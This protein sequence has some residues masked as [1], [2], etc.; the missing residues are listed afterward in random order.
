MMVGRIDQLGPIQPGGK[1]GKSDQVQG[2]DRTDVITLSQEAREKA[3]IFQVV[4]LI[5]AVPDLSDSQITA[6]RERINDPAYINGT[7]SATADRLMDVFG[8]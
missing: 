7:I 6:L 4:E 1:P 2:G 5:K 3:E 8:L